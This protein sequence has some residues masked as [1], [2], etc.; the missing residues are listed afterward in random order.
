MQ[1]PAPIDSPLAQPPLQTRRRSNS[2][3]AS[4]ALQKHQR[5]GASASAAGGWDPSTRE[6]ASFAQGAGGASRPGSRW[7]NTEGAG[8]LA[9]VMSP[10]D[11]AR[12]GPRPAR[13]LSLAPVLFLSLSFQ[14]GSTVKA[15]RSEQ[16]RW[17][18]SAEYIRSL[19]V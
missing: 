5:A 1:T 4:T 6:G 7:D 13:V 19:S 16:V 10:V 12:R 11:E 2:D 9:M 17:S 18:L 8:G 15:W 3:D 14:R